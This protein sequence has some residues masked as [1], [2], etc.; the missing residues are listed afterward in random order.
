[1]FPRFGRGKQNNSSGQSAPKRAT[2][3]TSA[4]DQPRPYFAVSLA[5]ACLLVVAMVALPFA[6]TGAQQGKIITLGENLSPDQRTEL[7]TFFGYKSGVDR[8]PITVTTDETIKAMDGIFP[9]SLITSAF[10]S[11]ALTCRELGDGLDVTTSNI[12]LVTPGLYAM[13]LVTAGIGDATLVVAAP[14]SAQA[15]G[16]TA[17]TGVFKTWEISPCDSGDTSKTRQRL[18]LKELTLTVQIGQSLLTADGVQKAT[19]IVLETQKTIVTEHLT[20]QSDIDKAI[21]KQQQAAGVTI[22]PA[23]RAQL[24]DLL[25]RLAKEKIDWS[26]FSAGWNIERPEANR[27][28]M[29][30]D[31]IAIRNA[32]ATATAEAASAMTATA[33][34]NM[35]ATANA[36]A[37]IDAQK[38]AMA[39]AALTATA[40]AQPTS[41]PIPSPT[42]TPS[43][44]PTPLPTAT[45]API[46]LSGTVNKTSG[47]QLAIVVDGSG[48]TPVSYVV[49]SAASIVLDGK[50]ATLDKVDKGDH[51]VMSVDGSTHHVT[52]LVVESAD[53]GGIPMEPVLFGCVGLLGLVV[54]KRKRSV[55]PFVVK[56]VSD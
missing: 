40:Q 22:S 31:G 48:D 35:T 2:G 23:L 6:K 43:P 44:S 11:T 3:R 54:V 55:E 9:A 4:R 1:M 15:Q 28:I 50:P 56:S 8:N 13:A 20:S 38:T 45:P 36:Q 30:G 24:V 32:R 21:G 27:I 46:G 34:A 49:D 19:D 51:A 10:S 14:A 29:T 37:T 53:T 25:T 42:A 7:L 12:T 17:L 52:E 39:E 41:T 26:T 5:I 33:E 18:A 47:G 16:M